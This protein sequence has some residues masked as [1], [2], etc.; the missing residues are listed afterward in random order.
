VPAQYLRKE[1]AQVPL[2]LSKLIA[3]ERPVFLKERAP[4]ASRVFGDLAALL[5]HLIKTLPFLIGQSESAVVVTDSAALDQAAQR[6]AD[7]ELLESDPE[8]R[9]Y[10]LLAR[11]DGLA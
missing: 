9:L 2:K 3:C 5:R 10:R 8:A 4:V 1:H 11:R 6:R 7:R